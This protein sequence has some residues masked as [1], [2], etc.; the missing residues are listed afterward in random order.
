[1]ARWWVGLAVSS[2]EAPDDVLAKEDAEETLAALYEELCLFVGGKLTVRLL[3]KELLRAGALTLSEV[4]GEDVEREELEGRLLEEIV[5]AAG[6]FG[7]GARGALQQGERNAVAEEADAEDFAQSLAYGWPA[8]H[9][10]P[11]LPRASLSWAL[12]DVVSVEVPDG[13]C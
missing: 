13:D 2:E 3:V 4:E 9:D 7:D 6:M 1:M 11:T 10:A 8:V 5:G 12:R